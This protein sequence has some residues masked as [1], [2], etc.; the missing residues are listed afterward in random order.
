MN[1][2]KASTLRK[3]QRVQWYDPDNENNWGLGFRV[4]S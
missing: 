4:I 3:M 2:L 1:Y